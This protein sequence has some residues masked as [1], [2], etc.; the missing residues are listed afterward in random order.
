MIFIL[1]PTIL[2]YS[3]YSYYKNTSHLCFNSTIKFP[4][5]DALDVF[6]K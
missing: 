1:R 4:K 3:G 5:S 6:D 2:P